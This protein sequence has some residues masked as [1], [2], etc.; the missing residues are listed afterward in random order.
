MFE[1]PSD[2][3]GLDDPGSLSGDDSDLEAELRQITSGG[4]AKPR[5]KPKPLPAANLD[6]LVASSM[7]DIPSDEDLSG[8]DD[9]PD[10]MDELKELTQGETE[11][12]EPEIVQPAEV[13]SV[14]LKTLLAERLKMYE[15]AEDVA[16]KSGETTRAR[17]FNRGIKTIKDL[18]K[19]N[20]AGRPINSE[21]IPP[22]VSTNIPKKH[23][24]DSIS[25]PLEPNPVS[26]SLEPAP[27]PPVET[28]PVDQAALNILTQRRDEYKLAAV[29]LKRS[30]DVPTAI[31]YMK[32]AKQFDGVIKAVENGEQVD[33]RQMPGSPT[34]DGPGVQE[35]GNF[36]LQTAKF[37]PRNWRGVGNCFF[38]NI[39]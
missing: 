27:D 3:S 36:L 7:K 37:Y 28:K 21:D 30:G 12:V 9:D 25:A 35:A 2:L 22:E 39:S 1:I 5:Q 26:A 15:A 18:M 23:T 4:A 17:R 38:L 32:I 6:T 10:L 33:L 31:T 16:K 20:N 29:K 11:E 8:D 14:D 34:V 13:A 24:P 19:Q